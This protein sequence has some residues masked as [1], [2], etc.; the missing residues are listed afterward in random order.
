[1]MDDLPKEPGPQPDPMLRRGRVNAAWL[2]LA[3]IVAVVAIVAM[4]VAISPPLSSVSQNESQRGPL[5]TGTSTPQQSVVP[6]GRGTAGAP[7][8]P[9]TTTGAGGDTAR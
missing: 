6:A 8:G 7:A 4:L 2:W 9:N 3:G 1:M 5:P